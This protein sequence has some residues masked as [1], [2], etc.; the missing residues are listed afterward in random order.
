MG[1][2]FRM[3]RDIVHWE[4]FNDE[5]PTVLKVWIY[6]MA[7]SNYEDSVTSDGRKI[8]KGQTVFSYRSVSK[9][10]HISERRVRTAVKK[11]VATHKMTHE[12]THGYS[13]ATLENTGFQPSGY[14]KATHEVTHKT[15]TSNNNKEEEL[16]DFGKGLVLH[17]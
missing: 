16:Y 12:A 15:T 17:R 10:L 1:L 7:T 11:L 6:L 5:D 13:I 8:K 3:D 9:A 2:W 14:S 4:M